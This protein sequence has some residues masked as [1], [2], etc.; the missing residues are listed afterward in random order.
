RLTMWNLND[1]YEG[2]NE[3]YQQDIQT[4]KS[5]MEAFKSFIETKDNQDVQ[6]FL[7]TYLLKEEHITKLV[8]TL[9]A[10]ASLKYSSNVNDPEP[11]G[12]MAT[13]DNVL[14]SVTK[15]NVL[16]T[17]YIANC[18]I[19]SLSEQSEIIKKYAYNLNRTKASATYLL[20]ESEETLVAKFQEVASDS[21]RRLQQMLTSNLKVPFRDKTITLSEV[22]NLAY[23]ADPAKR[24]D[25]YEAELKALETIDDPIALAITNIKRQ[26]NMMN[27]FR[28]YQS[29]LEP[30]LRSSKMTQ[31]TLDALIQAME[32]YRPAFANYLKAK[33][34]YLGHQD[35]LPFYDLFA[36]VGHGSKT[37]TY[38]EAKQLVLDAFYGFSDRLGNFAKRAF[39]EEWIDVEPRKG[40]VGGAFCSN[41]P[42]IGQS[43]ILTNFTGS[44]SD[45]LT[46]AHELGHGFHGDIIKDNDPLHWSY[47]MPLAETASIFC[48][49]IVND[50]LLKTIDDD[51]LKLNVLENALQGDTQV[52]IDILSRFYFETNLFQ[53]AT[54]PVQASELKSMM[55]NAQDKAYQDGLHK[56]IKHPYMWLMKPHYYSAGLNFYNFPYAF[57]L[58]FGKGLFAMYKKDPSSFT[59]D[60]ETLLAYTTKADVE[61]VAKTMNIDVTQQAFWDASL[62]MVESDLLEV[63]DLFKKTKDA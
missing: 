16:M 44:L 54:K 59:E 47:P 51:V 34:E 20:S 5:H 1:L 62:K 40:K 29:P 41:Q 42:Q 38:E 63:I 61:D 26:V 57:G 35:G 22:R 33:A 37:F 39:D 18:D 25:A 19:E 52:I 6:T 15:E 36:P 48:E 31:V 17:R 30:T 21:W 13:L 28:G 14:K 56:D 2:F 7:E 49:A 27:G 12:Y 45:V 60:Y 55:L 50:Y 58:L 24:K 10:F 11:L 46:L 43:R 9:Y 8:R 53:E 3:K 4:L 23:E 32:S